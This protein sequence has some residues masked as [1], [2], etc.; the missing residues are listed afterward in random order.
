MKFPLNH[1]YIIITKVKI[2]QLQ[3]K[4]SDKKQAIM[5]QAKDNWSTLDVYTVC[6]L[7]FLSAVIDTAIRGSFLE[8]PSN[9]RNN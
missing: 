9:S 3:Q 5:I 4:L 8:R 2:I 6:N 1:M 7:N